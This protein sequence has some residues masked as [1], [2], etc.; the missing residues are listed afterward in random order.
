MDDENS[1]VRRHDRR[2]WVR[3]E[4]DIVRTARSASDEKKIAILLRRT[5]VSVIVRRKR[6]GVRFS[7]RVRT[8]PGRKWTEEELN[9]VRSAY[10]NAKTNKDV[11]LDALAAQLGRAKTVVCGKAGELGLTSYTRKRVK[12]CDLKIKK[13]MFAT[14][15]EYLAHMRLRSKEWH[16][17]HE[18]PRGHL[19]K[20]HTP[21]NRAKL[22]A[23][24][25]KAWAD[26]NHAL[27]SEEAKQRRSDIMHQRSLDGKLLS[28]THIYSRCASGK[29][30]D[31][32]DRFFRSAWEANYARYLNLLVAQKQ[33]RE[34][35]YECQTFQFEKIK[36]GTRCYTPDFKVTFNDGHHEWHEVKGWM[37]DKSRVRLDRMALYYPSEVVKIIGADWFKS[38]N[39]GIAH[40]L[41]L[42]E[43]GG[44]KDGGPSGRPGHVNM[45]TPAIGK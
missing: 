43:R 23:G 34:W 9:I 5:L 44:K 1:P 10:E 30:A 19:G 27:N 37:D 15:D 8:N 12:P 40:V 24:L 13:P 36:R 14:K 32:G 42:W 22:F 29:R 38:A 18:H 39:R 4:D 45:A 20:K 25:A 17:T 33:I 35:D 11:G 3:D 21:E 41:P 2:S 6:L 26:P 16:R 31:L 7:A 28:G